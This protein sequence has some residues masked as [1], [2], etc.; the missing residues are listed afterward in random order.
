[1]SSPFGEIAGSAVQG[2]NF[3]KMLVHHRLP[4]KFFFEECDIS[5]HIFK[6]IC[7]EICL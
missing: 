5:E 1:M 2:R 6:R 7:S 3:I 4:L